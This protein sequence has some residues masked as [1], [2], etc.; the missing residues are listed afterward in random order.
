MPIYEF[1]CRACHTI[2]QFLARAAGPARAPACPRCAAP[3]LERRPS[4]FAIS[5]GRQEP[6]AAGGEE[7]GDARL[8]R[9]F[10][11]MANESDGLNEDDPRSAARFLRRLY[12]TAGLEPGAGLAEALCRLEAG[13]DP[14][15][16]EEDLGDVLDEAPAADS[17]EPKTKRL[18]RRF[19]PPSVDPELHEL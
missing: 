14:D 2:Y 4:S 18:R 6:D 19:L 17:A 16:I 12:Q 5:K 10:A 11:Q 15:S 13:E 8:E 1:Y 7:P 9:A 3:E